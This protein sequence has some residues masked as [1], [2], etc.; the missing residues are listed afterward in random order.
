[1]KKFTYSLIYS[2][3]F[4]PFSLSAVAEEDN[5]ALDEVVVSGTSFSQ[6]VGTQKIKQEQIE[7]LPTT[8][9]NITDL[10]KSNSAV[11]FSQDSNTSNAGGE[12]RPD[13]VS[14]HGENYYSNN[15]II[16]GMSNN[17]NINP[18]AN[19]SAKYTASASPYNLPEGGTQ[20]MWIDTSLLKSAEIFDSNVSAKYGDFKGGVV[21]A[22]LKDP[23]I[24]RT[25][26]KVF[27]RTTRDSWASF[28]IDPKKLDEFNN[29]TSLDQQ[30]K[31]K[32]QIYGFNLNQPLSDKAAMLFSYSRTVSDI[33][34]YHSK[35]VEVDKT[36]KV[37][38]AN[39]SQPQQ[40]T[41]ESF[42]WK[43]VYFP[44]NGDAWRLTAIYNPHKSKLTRNNINAGGY[45][46]T[47]GGFQTNVDWEKR[48]DSVKM[49]TYFGYKQTSD[50]VENDESDY[51]NYVLDLNKDFPN[52]TSA[53][54]NGATGLYDGSARYASPY[55]GYGKFYTRKT[56]YTLKQDYSVNEFDWGETQ[57][58]IIFGW[59]ADYSKAKYVRTKDTSL[60][61]YQLDKNVICGTAEQCIDGS[62]YAYSRQYYAARN[63]EVN[64]SNFAMYLEDSMKWKRLD[65]NLGARATYNKGMGNFNL[66]PRFST[67]Y[68]VFGDGSTRVFGGINRYYS[69]S[70]L[71]RKLNQG[72]S[73]FERMTRELDT[74]RHVSNWKMEGESS[75]TTR[76]LDNKVKTP[77]SDEKVLGV[78]QDVL[79]SNVTFKW[80]NRRSKDD[81]T[82]TIRY[83]DGIGYRT[84]VNEGDRR[85]DTF[86]IDIKPKE[87]YKF[88]YVNIAWGLNA[89]RSVSKSNYK[90]Y[91][92]AVSDNTSRAVYN[93]RLLDNG[94]VPPSDF[95][96]PWSI[97]FNLYTEFPKINL[98]WTQTFKF[99]QGRDYLESVESKVDCSYDSNRSMCGDYYGLATEYRDAKVGSELSVDWRFIYKQ[100][101]FANQFL[102]VTLDINNVL[103]RKSVAS[104]ASGTTYYKMGRNFWLG[105]S[106]NW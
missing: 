5:L 17:E 24:S 103:N 105:A 18:G 54:P 41:N 72:V 15:F 64:D 30:S 21:N 82:A 98:K 11:R 88:E 6:Q 35:L 62:Q 63:I 70:L 19:H 56:T 25:S 31:F 9:G 58:N 94:E 65:I 92:E 74:S 42:L 73:T 90:S 3:L 97:G 26:G 46:T 52:W 59:Q 67:S 55:G 43:G 106:Y 75:S 40:R 10:L 16:D 85:N 34:F 22:E 84:F 48:F 28:F 8:N 37:S 93:K 95:N 83:I 60:F 61:T 104:A 44:D 23:D 86:S 53:N 32:K 78:S 49:K 4:L 76:S 36:G 39:I 96:T 69:G 51:H 79:N 81:L 89:S 100:P 20:S 2:S 91:N 13:E 50:I 87:A 1:M 27:Y 14:F 77:Y 101:T 57:H 45:E 71:Y 80:V 29:S 7:A 99:T 47:G 102:E 68:D 66:S 38:K 12:I 33:D